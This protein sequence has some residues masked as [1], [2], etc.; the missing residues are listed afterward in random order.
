MRILYISQYFPPEAGATQ[1]RAYEMARNLVR[2]GHQVTLLAEIPNHPSGVIPPEYRGKWVERAT[3]EGIDVIRLW[4]KASPV[5]GFRQRMLFYLSFMLSSTLA[6]LFLARGRYDLVFATSPP[7]FVGA[8]GLIIALLKR[9]PFIF[10]VRDIWPASAVALG[11]LSN[12]RAI[13][14]A[15]WLEETCYARAKKIVVV[16]RGIRLSLEQ[17]GIPQEKL[18]LIPNGANTDLFQYRSAA[19]HRLRADLNLEDKFIAVYAGIHGVAQGLETLLEAAFLFKGSSRC[20]LSADRRRTQEE[21]SAR[22]IPSFGSD[23]PD[24]LAGAAQGAH[25]RL[26]FRCGCRPDPPAQSRDFQFSPAIQDVRCLGLPAPRP[27]QRAWRSPAAHGILPG[28]L[29]R[30]PRRCASL[31][32]RDSHLPE[33]ASAHPPVG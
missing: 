23:Q 16:T 20:A 33:R 9:F 11:E 4:V 24:L 1:T 17:R 3:L 29:V 31:E 6:G 32:S 5:K 10:E 12:P 7:L 28:R 26:P 13:R 30:R 18:A 21:G 14:W 19:R 8:S 22:F 15:T 27:A 2:L 25:P